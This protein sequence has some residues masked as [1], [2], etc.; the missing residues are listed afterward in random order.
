MFPILEVNT[1]PNTRV[2]ACDFSETAV[3]LVKQHPEYVKS[4][5]VSNENIGK[6]CEAFVCDI[7]KEQDWEANAPFGEN[8]LGI[9]YFCL[10]S[11]CVDVVLKSMANMAINL[12]KL[13]IV[14]INR[15][16]IYI[17]C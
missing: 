1:H 9:K 11:F 8:S 15:P 5:Q 6:R 10:S 14:N 4:E 16:K 13:Y 7:T 3:E 17:I 12:V 2:Y